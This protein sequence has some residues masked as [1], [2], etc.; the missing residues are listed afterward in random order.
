MFQEVF[1]EIGEAFQDVGTSKTVLN[2]AKP[3]C[4]PARGIIEPLFAKYGV[5]LYDIKEKTLLISPLDFVRRMKI[6]LRN[7]ENLKF[8]PA[9]LMWLPMALQAKV[10]VKTSQ[11]RWAEYLMIRTGR[12]YVPGRYFDQR[13]QAWAEKHNGNLPPAWHDK[14][15]WIERSCKEGVE[16]WKVLKNNIKGRS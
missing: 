10:T 13:N 1:Q 7:W 15:P 9:A 12:L 11:A 6:E 8:G 5:K 4:L 2:I 16:K 14:K 3:F